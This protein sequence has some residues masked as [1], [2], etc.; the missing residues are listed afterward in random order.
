MMLGDLAVLC[1][2]TLIAKL[3]ANGAFEETLATLAADGAVVPPG[4]TVATHHA[5]LG[6]EAEAGGG[7]RLHLYFH[8]KQTRQRN[9]STRTPRHAK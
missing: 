9:K 8:L 5:Q 3:L 2:A 4:G 1:A 7:G 6:A